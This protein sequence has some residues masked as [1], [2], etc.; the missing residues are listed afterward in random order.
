MEKIEN[1]L[2]YSYQDKTPVKSTTN[3][4][5]IARKYIGQRRA[6]IASV[7]KSIMKT[8]ERSD[9]KSD[10]EVEHFL[11][12]NEKLRMAKNVTEVLDIVDSE[13][14]SEDNAVLAVTILY[15]FVTDGINTKGDF[16]SDIRF[17]K[18]QEML[19]RNFKSGNRM[20]NRMPIHP[21][22]D[23]S[24]LGI[25]QTQRVVERV[26]TMSVIELLRV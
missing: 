18:L 2:Y 12:I 8:K 24:Q 16:E 3:K 5:Q 6:G 10:P 19:N 17:S 11:I 13:H 1:F 21:D 20:Q 9:Y 25:L 23:L 4:D 26:K 15:K 7:F 14:F 22:Q